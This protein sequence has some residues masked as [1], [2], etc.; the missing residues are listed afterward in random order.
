M[1]GAPPIAVLDARGGLV[2]ANRAAALAWDANSPG[3]VPFAFDAGRLDAALAQLAAHPGREVLLDC[4]DRPLARL[5]ACEGH[6]AVALGDGAAGAAMDATTRWQFALDNSDEG[7]W[8]WDAS[9]DKVYY[10]SIWK[11]HLGYADAEI[12]DTFAEWE[13]RVHPDDRSAVD[14]ALRRHFEGVDAQYSPLHRMRHKDGSWRWILTRGKVVS[15]NPDGSPRRIVGAHRDVTGEQKARLALEQTRAALHDFISAVPAHACVLAPDGTIVQT[16][17]PWDDHYVAHGGGDPA[18]LVG[19]NY[20]DACEVGD[21]AAGE[22]ASVAAGIRDVIGGRSAGFASVYACHGVDGER[23]YDLRV[24]PL[25]GPLPRSV[26]VWHLDITGRDV[27]S[28]RLARVAAHVPGVIYQFRLR[29]DGTSHFPYASEGIRT[30]YGVTPEEVREDATAVFARL[31]PDDLARV[32]A[33]IEESARALEPWRC[34]YRVRFEDGREIWVEGYATPRRESGAISWHGYITDITQRKTTELALVRAMADLG[35]Y[36]RDLEDFAAIA[37]HDLQ[38]PLRK[39]RLFGGRLLDA[40]TSLDA[41]HRDY[42]Q[43]MVAATGR[44]S[45]L[46]DDLLIYARAGAEPAAAVPVPLG[47]LVAGVLVDLEARIEATSARIAV[48][49]LP[50]VAGEA[51]QLRQVFQNLL[52]NALKFVVADRVPEIAI[53]AVP[54]DPPPGAAGAW[55][56]IAVADNGIGFDPAQAGAIFAPFRRLHDRSSYEGTGIG[57]AIVRR[58]V[59]RH[60]GSVRAEARPGEGA[61]FRLLLP[62]SR[63]D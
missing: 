55:C 27:A 32:A 38:E 42:L 11:A 57:L 53:A 22:G 52:G 14:A 35:A 23:W 41:E 46:I 24:T 31:H 62:L 37:S 48:G 54:A 9:T 33:S 50:V 15:W 10:S 58:V 44:M 8:D 26:V 59:E 25:P 21:D 2:A 40:A 45:E 49:P 28:E 63:T 43:R 60:G 13:S 30:I 18:R 39:I 56:E 51:S 6:G 4:G 3:G 7:L 61:T 12:G 19:S 16:N 1:D 36:S 5:R 29:D 20:F 17:Q 47:P 34:E